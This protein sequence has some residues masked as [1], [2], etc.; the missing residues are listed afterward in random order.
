MSKIWERYKKSNSYF[1]ENQIIAKANWYSD[2]YLGDQWKELKVRNGKKEQMPV[3]NFTKQV[4]DYKT[5][6]I[7]QNQMA[8]V[9]SDNS[10]SESEIY[11]LLNRYW[12]SRW[13]KEGMDAKMYELIKASGIQGDGYVFFSKEQAEI[14]PDTSILLAD[15]QNY[16]LQDQEY[17]MIRSRQFIKDVKRIGRNN[18]V[19]EEDLNSIRGDVEPSYQVGNKKDISYG[20]TDGKCTVIIYFE[21]IDGVV[22]MAK[23]TEWC[24]YEPLHPLAQ[25]DPNS[26]QILQGCKLYPLAK[27]CCS[28]VPN[29][30]RGRGWVQ[31][32]IPNQLELNKTYARAGAAIQTAAYPRIAYNG[33]ALE[34]PEALE[35]AGAPLEVNGNAQTIGQMISYLQGTPMTG[36]VF[37]YMEKMMTDTKQVAGASD[38][39][40]GISDPTRVSGTAIT[41]IREQSTLTLKGNVILLKQ[42]YEDIARIRLDSWQTY[43]PDGVDVQRAPTPDEE[44][45]LK[46]GRSVNLIEHID[47]ET[48]RNLIPNITIDVSLKTQS[49][50]DGA[51]A[52]LDQKLESG[53]ITFEE[54]VEASDEDGNVPKAKLLK[55]L[56]IRKSNPNI[57]NNTGQPIPQQ[58]P[59]QQL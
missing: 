29:S 51:Q 59:Q 5:A 40:T 22:H 58:I 46:Q 10:K 57:D 9:F 13:D 44:E 20:S 14:L 15:E 31:D 3:M 43:Y 30:A 17:V 21:K 52:I 24:D 25:T 47:G 32:L 48:L 18:G 38:A 8:A 37:N 1:E 39:I 50:K 36:D 41:E 35:E 54:W 49:T 26:G 28:K 53:L 19:P 4:V 16:N 45:L 56:E 6:A 42:C 11:K 7:G 55:I 27:L 23:S 34:N 2:M 12:E 33:N